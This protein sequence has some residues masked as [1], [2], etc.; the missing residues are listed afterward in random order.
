MF[1]VEVKGEV[2]RVF[3][4]DCL[5]LLIAEGGLAL[6]GG[7]ADHEMSLTICR[8]SQRARLWLSRS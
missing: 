1:V 3:V 5:D 8:P 4:N 7:G 2:D 6:L